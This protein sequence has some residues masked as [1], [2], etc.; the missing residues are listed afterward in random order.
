VPA[1]DADARGRE[2][3][4]QA[5]S[6]CHGLDYIYSARRSPSEWEAT[7]GDMIGRGA[8]L[9]EGER[10]VLLQFLSKYYAP[11]KPRT[12][13]NQA[14]AQQLM[15][16]LGLSAAEAEEVARYRQQHG[17]IYGWEDLRKVPNLDWKK[18][19]AKRDVVAFL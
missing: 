7:V 6:V 2:V 17:N 15:T 18:L 19:E 3:A 5:C 1:R 14:S 11:E 8:P 9:L 13:I 12:N 10:E 16:S 4:Q